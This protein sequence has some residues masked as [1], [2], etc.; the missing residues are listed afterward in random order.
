M[1]NPIQPPAI[2]IRTASPS[3]MR[4][5]ADLVRQADAA[6]RAVGDVLGIDDDAFGLLRRLIGNKAQQIAIIFGV[7]VGP[8]RERCLAPVT[9]GAEG[10]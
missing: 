6:N 7:G 9:I 4:P 5:A 10:Q 2:Y 1:R 3:R 8:R